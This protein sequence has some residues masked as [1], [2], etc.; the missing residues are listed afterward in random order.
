MGLLDN[1]SFSIFT[2]DGSFSASQTFALDD[3]GVLIDIADIGKYRNKWLCV[4]MSFSG[5][6]HDTQFLIRNTSQS[7][8]YA[9][10]G[11]IF[12]GL[13]SGR[14]V[15]SVERDNF[16]I[17]ILFPLSSISQTRFRLRNDRAAVSGASVLYSYAFVD[18]I[19]LGKPVQYIGR[20]VIT[21]TGTGSI[22][23]SFYMNYY[24]VPVDLR[25]FK[26]FFVKVLPLKND[27]SVQ[28]GVNY[29]FSIQQRIF[30]ES[31]GYTINSGETLI[32]GATS[33]FVSD[34]LSM[35][36]DNGFYS[37]IKVNIHVAETRYIIEFYGVR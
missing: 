24:E 26:Y 36:T 28:T 23:A 33:P 12:Y 35:T 1:N 31:S 2:K 15:W 27:G 13:T 29:D 8:F 32:T 25:W 21:P 5:I 6:S 4:N 11:R 22:S 20:S 10:D 14:D 18:P 17:T 7:I 16:K 9:D 30:R 3:T 37:T 34:F 19:P